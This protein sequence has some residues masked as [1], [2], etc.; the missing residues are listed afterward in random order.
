MEK[1]PKQK[2][3]I[4]TVAD[5][6]SMVSGPDEERW[7]RHG[8][9]R[10][11]QLLEEDRL[12]G[13]QDFTLSFDCSVQRYFQVARWV[14]ILDPVVAKINLVMLHLRRNVFRSDINVSHNIVP[15]DLAFFYIR[16]WNNSISCINRI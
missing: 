16:L 11:L 10:R 7:R 3:K 13:G 2:S 14:S 4:K 12:K 9:A 6:V 5:T 8:G 1:A 15:L